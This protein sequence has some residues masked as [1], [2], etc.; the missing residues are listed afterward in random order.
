MPMAACLQWTT[1]L[2][3]AV[4]DTLILSHCNF[5][6]SPCEFFS[7]K[8]GTCTTVWCWATAF[9]GTARSPN[10]VIFPQQN[11]ERAQQTKAVGVSNKKARTRCKLHAQDCNSHAS[12]CDVIA[13][14]SKDTPPTYVCTYVNTRVTAVWW[15]LVSD[16]CLDSY[17]AYSV[18]FWSQAR[19]VSARINENTLGHLASILYGRQMQIHG[20]WPEQC[21][22]TPL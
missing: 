22:Q 9:F 5:W 19:W 17:V 11:W 2:S 13:I 14:A 10:A 4:E 3:N 15:C 18:F 12:I 16:E 20:W 1:Y 7:T 8:L 6:N 21:R